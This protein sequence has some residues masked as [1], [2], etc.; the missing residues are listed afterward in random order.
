[1]LRLDFSRKFIP[2]VCFILLFIASGL[3]ASRMN[4]SQ[5]LG[6]PNQFFTFFQF[7]GP[8]AGGL[9]GSVLGALVVLFTQTLD[10]VMKGK[11]V[12]ALD[13]MRVLPLVFAAWYFGSQDRN[14]WTALI[15]LAAIALFVL[16]P[17]GRQVWYFAVL[18]WSIPIAAKLVLKDNL[19][20]KSLGSTLTAHAVGGVIWLYALPTTPEFWN[21][22]IPVVAYER[23]LF[24]LG[25]TGSFILAN[26][27]LSRFEV[28]DFIKVNRKLPFAA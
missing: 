1:M 23:A 15:P 21:A 20:A 12:S 4:F 27:L 2:K 24:A 9:L 8:V 5:L 19:L 14:K 17:V 11:A 25:I 6:A 18:F 16:H 22:L 28:P 10:L 3:I 7:F 26:A 13:L